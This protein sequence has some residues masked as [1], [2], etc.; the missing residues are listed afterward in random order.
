MLLRS[1]P[2]CAVLVLSWPLAGACREGSASA[3]DDFVPVTP[4]PAGTQGCAPTTPVP[5]T[6]TPV[7]SGAVIGPLSQIAA[8]STG[9]TLYLTGAD[10][11]IHRLDFPLGGG[12]PTDTVLVAAGVIEADLLVPA[13]IASAATLS[14]VAVLDAQTLIVAEHASNTLLAVRRDLPDSVLSLAGLPLAT[15]GYADGVAGGIRFHFGEPATLLAAADDSVYV[16]DTENHALRQ[17]LLGTLS[18][19]ATVTGNGAPGAAVG[20]LTVT[21][22]DTPSGI[23]AS[24]AG[25][26]LVVE[27][28]RA[29]FGGQRLLSLA[30]GTPSIFGGFDG[31]ARALAGDGTDA[32][33]QGVDTLA[34]LGTP[35][36]LALTQDGLVYW[37]DARDGIL[38]RHDFASGLSGCPLFA[39]CA[40]AVQAGGSFSGAHFS[41]AI[42]ASGA[43]YVLA[44][45]AGTL[46]RVD[47]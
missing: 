46:F 31:T 22:L 33:T 15:G 12:A 6:L 9:E 36:G 47:P 18:E 1:W 41:L 37:V 8:T 5:G 24:C 34:Q 27:S 42:G 16:C 7:F 13:G 28:G 17:V 38:R 4:A 19:S 21:R 25:E 30:I 40:A 45:D 20:A 32:T 29:G 23:A 44:A 39:D 35:Q 2:R 3:V 10:G 14:G 11:S 43:L 26:V